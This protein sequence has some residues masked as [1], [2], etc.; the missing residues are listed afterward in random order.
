MF[1]R[2]FLSICCVVFALLQH[3]QADWAGDKYSMF[4]HYGLYSIPGG[5]W[6][7]KPVTRGYSEQILTFGIGFSDW[8]EAYTQEFGARAF[9]AEAIVA[10]AKAGGM[11][12]IVMTAKHHDGFC[13]FRTATTR[14]NVYDAT[15]ARRDLLAELAEACHKQGMGFGIYFS[16]I[17]WH[18]PGAMPFSS[19]NADPITPSHHEYNK[20]QV[21]ELLTRYGKVDELWFDMGSQT[22]AQSEELYHLVH[23]LQPDCM[24]SG[25]LGNDYADFCVLPDNQ[26]PDYDMMLPWQTAASMFH[27]TWG[28]RSWQERGKVSD[29]VAEKLGHLVKVVS[30]GGKYLLNIG[31]MGDGSVV[32]FEHEVISRIGEEITPMSEAIY[33]TLPGPFTQESGTPAVTLSKDRRSMY[34]FVPRGTE[35]IELPAVK[36]KVKS[37]KLLNSKASVRIKRPES[38]L[39]L[40]LK[41]SKGA[42]T[43]LFSVVKLRFDAP[44]EVLRMSCDEAALHLYNATPLYAQSSV[45]YYTTFRSILG[46]QWDIPESRSLS[47]ITFTDREVG[48]NIILKLGHTEI[49]MTLTPQ[50]T[51]RKAFSAEEIKWIDCRVAKQR[52]LFGNVPEE[53]IS[54]KLSLSTKWVDSPHLWK[55]T[56]TVQGH[57]SHYL[58]YTISTETPLSL[59]LEVAYKDGVLVYLDGKYIAG[60]LLHPAKGKSSDTIMLLLPLTSGTHTLVFKVYSRWGGALD[61]ALSVPK[62]YSE[63]SLPLNGLPGTASGQRR[64][65]LMKEHRIPFA[66]PARLY[67]VRLE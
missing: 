67:N 51:I 37:A 43:P 35:T 13:L 7:G 48:R 2:L 36:G 29:K 41:P 39:S 59:P 53:L 66:S 47:R 64:I 60:E 58:R 9:D 19:H 17:D 44:V 27:E 14:Y 54:P 15:P 61:F 40:T 46:Y 5:V 56:D 21:A 26:F 49:P 65:T 6:D 38:R 33:N 32:P 3:V 63:H 25:R 12:S 50:E 30:M 45:D 1:R 24:V 34:I 16:L 10:L 31:P 23:R 28:Y 52:G 8:Y 55:Y 22:P 11:R 18:F 57:T 4:I 42:D 62:A 20:A